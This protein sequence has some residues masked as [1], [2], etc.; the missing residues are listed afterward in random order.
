MNLQRFW[1]SVH[2]AP[3]KCAKKNNIEGGT[4]VK[5][6]SFNESHKN[7]LYNNHEIPGIII[8]H[9]AERSLTRV[10]KDKHV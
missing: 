9:I 7:I 4:F 6:I 1:T 5:K 2:K 10:Y 8:L 3:H